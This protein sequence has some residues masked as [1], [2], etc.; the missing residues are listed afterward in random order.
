M[1]R[2]RLRIHRSEE[3]H[4]QEHRS[5]FPRPTPQPQ[6]PAQRGTLDPKYGHSL[7]NFSVYPPGREPQLVNGEIPMDWGDR[8]LNLTQP[9][10]AVEWAA[11]KAANEGVAGSVPLSI[12][13]LSG[14]LLAR[15]RTNE[16]SEASALQRSDASGAALESTNQVGTDA[17]RDTAP[18][19]GLL[20]LKEGQALT[21]EQ[22]QQAAQRL[23]MRA[24][25]PGSES[26]G[27]KVLSGFG[28]LEGY[29]RRK[30]SPDERGLIVE[31]IL[32][33][34]SDWA[35]RVKSLVITAKKMG[36]AVNKRGQ[37]LLYQGAPMSREQ[38]TFDAF[39]E[40]LTVN[41]A[42]SNESNLEDKEEIADLAKGQISHPADLLKHFGYSSDH[43]ISGR[44]GLQ[45]RVF[46]PI[47]A[48]KPGH[49]PKYQ[50]TIVAFRGTEGVQFNTNEGSVDTLLADLAKAQA[51]YN[52]YDPNAELI[53]LNLKHAAQRAKGG[54]GGKVIITGHS[55]GG[56]LAQIAAVKHKE[57][58]R[59]IVTFQSPAISDAD[60]STL[61]A[62]NKA[63]PKSQVNSRHYRVDGD[64]VPMA[65]DRMTPGIITSFTRSEAQSGQPFTSMPKIN[66]WDAGTA[67][68]AYELTTLLENRDRSELNADEKAIVDSGANDRQL[69]GSDGKPTGKQ[70]TTQYSGQQNTAQDNRVNAEGARSSVG[71]LLSNRMRYEAFMAN[72]AYNTLLEYVE[73]RAK[74]ADHLN[75]FVKT[76]TTWIQ[77]VSKLPL[78]L[79]TLAL[80]EEADAT[81]VLFPEFGKAK[82]EGVE[83]DIR[84]KDR[85]LRR[86][87]LT[88]RNWHP[89]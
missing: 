31:Y 77:D 68:V 71:A 36:I 50:E 87:E 53:D 17:T 32:I 11:M 76:T 57:I 51:G 20:E 41:L 19:E 2:E 1:K 15:A 67:H 37:N 79:S 39:L 33:A 25:L 64:V 49:N 18:S 69:L 38:L 4:Q 14:P 46:S 78:T 55:L 12:P 3:E 84:S 29:F 83:I 52:Q 70:V 86:L 16:A 5:V 63:N 23:M 13:A 8:K 43:A 30:L 82:Q 73:Q 40:Q 21:P 56:A 60:V 10:D 54:K 88:W 24:D 74:S 22:A 48:G 89:A 81:R 6:E 65:G 62:Y 9:G 45:F 59:D 34:C 58:T 75:T 7:E 44:W 26:F 72:L 66:P 28:P 47:P 85:V 80:A 61:E 42:Y 27:Q 35:E